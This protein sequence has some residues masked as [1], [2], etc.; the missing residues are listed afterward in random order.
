MVNS[1]SNLNPTSQ[2]GLFSLA[3]SNNGYNPS[4]LNGARPTPDAATNYPSDPASVFVPLTRQGSLQGSR[5]SSI[6][7]IELEAERPDAA[8]RE[9]E[10]RESRE[11]REGAGTTTSFMAV[12]PPPP[13]PPVT[14]APPPNEST[15]DVPQQLSEPPEEEDDEVEEAERTIETND[16]S[17]AVNS[18]DDDEPPPP[19]LGDSG[20]RGSLSARGG[21]RGA[22]DLFAALRTQQE[23]ESDHP[24]R[25][26]PSPPVRSSVDD[27]DDD[28]PPNA[29]FEESD[30]LYSAASYSNNASSRL[31]SF[32]N[33]SPSRHQGMY[34]LRDFGDLTSGKREDDSFISRYGG[35]LRDMLNEN[36]ERKLNDDLPNPVDAEDDDD[37]DPPAAADED[38]AEENEE[39][40]SGL[41]W[42]NEAGEVSEEAGEPQTDV[43]SMD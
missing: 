15:P 9:R 19:F 20:R 3:S 30:S 29:P 35:T 22:P 28:D 23:A 38:N 1:N 14:P 11:A 10:G 7:A 43:E 39:G 18:I 37:D 26:L 5:G 36:S 27:I 42:E 24:A 16:P 6:R 40:K 4:T 41:V 17:L 2:A 12:K 34:G 33:L 8:E 13:A 32:D 31:N 25:E 21:A